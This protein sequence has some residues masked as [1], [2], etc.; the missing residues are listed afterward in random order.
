MT[1]V[2][3]VKLAYSNFASGNVPWALALFDPAIEWF[4]YKGMPFVE[5]DGIFIGPEAVLIN[6]FMNLPVF[7]N[8]FN[9]L[10]TEIFGA[11]DKVVMVGYSLAINRATGNTFKAIPHTCMDDKKWKIDS[12]FPSRGY[13]CNYYLIIVTLVF[14]YTLIK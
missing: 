1:N 12:F 4:E 7:F 3:L 2:D 11:N 6:V 13:C 8:G 14:I 5:G 10:P 9:I